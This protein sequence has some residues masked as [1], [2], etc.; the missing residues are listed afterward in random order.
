LATTEATGPGVG[1]PA[2][3]LA[4]GAAVGLAVGAAVGLAV[5]A[6]VGA[7]VGLAV[8]AAVGAGVGL[9]VGAA[10]GAGVGL[11]V[12]A[13]VGAAVGTGVGATV[14]LAVGAAVGAAVSLGAGVAVATGAA[15]GASLGRIDGSTVGRIG[16]ADTVAATIRAGGGW[17]GECGAIFVSSG[18]RG[19]AATVRGGRAGGAT[20]GTGNGRTVTCC[21]ARCAGAGAFRLGAGIVTVTTSAPPRSSGA[22][23]PNSTN[24]AMKNR[25]SRR[26]NASEAA[27]AST[28]RRAVPR[29][30]S[31]MALCSPS[32][33]ATL[34]GANA[35]P[36][37]ARIR[38]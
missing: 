1:G 37:H 6:A 38:A 35:E 20:G 4:V 2:V 31:C 5:G 9:A 29:S 22:T 33:G 21:G 27:Y 34:P 30:L 3:G 8:G 25:T 13:A 32:R 12:G 14:G 19:W 16:G 36:R 23:V 24:G 18:R 10:V 7:G 26:C 17:R 15:V 11:A 28:Y